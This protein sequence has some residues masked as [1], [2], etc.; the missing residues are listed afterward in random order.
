MKNVVQI[1]FISGNQL[2]LGYRQNT[3][4]FDQC[5]GF[6]SGRIE[7]GESP[8]NAAER[9]ALEE[10]SVSTRELSL[11]AELV[12]SSMS[13]R[14]YFYLCFDWVGELE[15]AESDL[16]RELRW[17]NINELPEECTPITYL[18]I[19]KIINALRDTQ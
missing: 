10:V 9:E 19:N 4:A 16:C 2:L 5:W 14:H 11:I 12:D 1:V 6:P 18:A 17:F 8:L 15:N 3:E 7:D 13:I